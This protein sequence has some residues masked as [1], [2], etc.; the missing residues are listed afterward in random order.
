[1]PAGDSTG[2]RVR[3]H[4]AS[5]AL[6]ALIASIAHPGAIVTATAGDEKGGCFV[7]FHT[8]CSIDPVRALVCISTANHTYEVAMRAEFL[9]VHYPSTADR[10]ITELFA[11]ETGD[12]IDKF[13]RCRWMSAEPGAVVLEDIDHWWIGERVDSLDLGDHVGIVLSPQRV[14]DGGPF[15]QLDVRTLST[16]E[17]GHPRDPV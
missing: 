2:T 15:D 13:A 1:M 4:D 5:P 8:Q 9:T 6:A 14:H 7:G 17:P 16:V 3:E 11:S 12:V 10:T